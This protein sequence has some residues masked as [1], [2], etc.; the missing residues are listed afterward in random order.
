M[1]KK[2]HMCR[3]VRSALFL[4]LLT[5]F[6]I[7]S[8]NAQSS[9]D[10]LE[11]EFSKIAGYY[12]D[13]FRLKLDCGSAKIYYTKDGKRPSHRS[14]RYKR[15]I[16]IS[17]NTVIRAIAYRKGKKG[18]VYTQTFFIGE[19]I[20]TIPVVSVT[21]TPSLLFNEEYGLY[22]EGEQADSSY[23]KWGANYWSR[24]E[25]RAHLEFFETDGSGVLS[26]ECGFRLFGG[27]SRQLAQKS[28]TFVARG[29]YGDTRFRH[30][31]FGSD[32]K[33]KNK[34]F[35]LRNSGSDWGHS[36][37]RDGFMTALVEDWDL[38]K[39]AY[40]PAH[41]YLN[42]KYWGLYNLREKINRHF[43]DDY[44]DIK[45]DSVD[46]MQHRFSRKR[47]SRT[48]YKQLLKYLDTVDMQ[49]VHVMNRLD[50]MMDVDNFMMYK[51]AQIYFDNKD[52]GGNI[53]YWRPQ[54]DKGRWR[55]IL[56]DTDWGFG[57]NNPQAYENNSLDFHTERDG[58]SWPNPVW[59]TFILRKL[60]KNDAFRQKFI[61]A[62]ID[63]IKC[64]FDPVYVVKIIEAFERNLEPEINRHLDRWNQDYDEWKDEVG[65][66]KR[67]GVNRPEHMLRHLS[68]YFDLADFHNVSVK[69]SVGG[70][71]HLN[72]RIEIDTNWFTN[73]YPSNNAVRLVAKPVLGFRFLHWEGLGLFSD[74]PTIEVFADKDLSLVAHFEF[75]QPELSNLVML[76]EVCGFNKSTGDWLEIYNNSNVFVDVHNWVIADN[77]G[78]E[79]ILPELNLPPNGFLVIA[80]N[81]EQFSSVFPTVPLCPKPLGFGLNKRKESLWLLDDSRAMID[82]A[83]YKV[84]PRDS[85][86]SI[87]L[88]LPKLDNADQE[89]WESLV[90]L[91]SPGAP[92][93]YYLS[94]QVEARKNKWI[95]LGSICGGVILTIY[96]LILSAIPKKRNRPPHELVV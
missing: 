28:M 53:K 62:F 68:E 10:L 78:N 56:Y 37:F 83:R 8:I 31:I 64:T 21:I 92:N 51:L 67:F 35:V 4:V 22:V 26:Q 58:P 87:N 71:V 29:K 2:C 43:I 59:S 47:G 27:M 72:H 5:L 90:G 86:Y 95:R 74:N 7:A 13:G 20:P 89:N 93:E 25:I 70:S 60:L 18:S 36:F 30:P 1:V 61:N 49:S 76:N 77:D 40:R 88:L 19:D 24:R 38:E 84:E 23:Y 91:G 81:R 82:H 6:G 16:S 52:A 42:G 66:M 54:E 80:E 12:S 65:N 63:E 79:Y 75:H 96:L 57:L 48:H 9:G 94:A 33:N 34:Y 17:K 45:K 11:V 46:I 55:W 14:R 44:H 41:V 3:I 15:P 73:R 32:G 69:S 39:Q 85:S 50:E